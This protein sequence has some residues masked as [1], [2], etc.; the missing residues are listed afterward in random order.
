MSF[1]K[2]WYTFLIYRWWSNL[3]VSCFQIPGSVTYLTDPQQGVE[4]T[5]RWRNQSNQVCPIHILEIKIY[6]LKRFI[7]W[8][9]YS[10]LFLSIV[11][12]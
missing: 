1:Y 2:I 3:N 10:V 8:Y 6:Y 9:M 7:Y 4:E 5:Q 11:Q 12:I